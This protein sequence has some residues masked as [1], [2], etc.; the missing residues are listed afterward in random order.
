MDKRPC[1]LAVDD[2]Q[3]IL[4]LISRALE[5][6]GFDVIVAENGIVAMELFDKHT[7]DLVILDVMMPGIDGFEVLDLIRQ[8][9]DVPVIMLSSK[10]EVTVKRD[11]LI[12]GAD[13]YIEKPF[14]IRDLSARIRAKIRRAAPKAVK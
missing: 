1:I 9:S 2:E 13:D 11:T 8:S 5:P 4:T 3:T 14:H 12:L 6:E 7:P 10:R